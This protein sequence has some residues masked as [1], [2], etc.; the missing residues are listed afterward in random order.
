MMRAQFTANKNREDGAEKNLEGETGRIQ[1][2]VGD[3]EERG[4]FLGCLMIL[5]LMIDHGQVQTITGPGEMAAAG[6]TGSA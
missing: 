1:Q 2:P 3:W 6:P 5:P 4:E